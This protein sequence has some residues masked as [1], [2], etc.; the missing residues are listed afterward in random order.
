MK[1]PVELVSIW[2]RP[3]ANEIYMIAGWHQWADA[4]SIS[5]GLPQYLV[6]LTNAHKIG[7]IRS[8]DF[9]LFQIPGTHHLLRPEIKFEDGFRTELRPRVNEFYYAETPQNGLI[10]FIG[11]E[12]HI[13]E[14]TYAAAFLHAAKEFGVK[15][16]GA[17]G[18]VYGS[19]PYDKDRDVSCTY[20]LRK[21]KSEL[22]NYALRY[23]NYEGGATIGSYF[24][25]RAERKNMEMFVWNAFVPSYDFA[26]PSMMPQEM[27]I[28]NDFRAWYELMRR[29]NHMYNLG[30]NLAEL[31]HQANELTN[32][33]EAKIE[34][35]EHEMPQL[36]IREYIEKVNEE[37]TENSFMNLDDVWERELGDLFKD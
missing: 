17:V 26:H 13:Y 34:E 4:G 30:I 9:Y 8:D 14:D 3:R 10:I 11:E 6:Q 15:R 37:F 7:E 16:I 22:D 32:A 5:S 33:L 18:G 35:L 21:M 28:E 29:F 2:D 27:R 25:D 19:M 31:D 20:S 24:I 36:R 12:P 23:S 1:N